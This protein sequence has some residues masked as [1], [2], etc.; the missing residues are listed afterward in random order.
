MNSLRLITQSNQRA[1]SASRS[2]QASGSELGFNEWVQSQKE[3]FAVKSE[4][5]EVTLTST[6]STS[7]RNAREIIDLTGDL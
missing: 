2:W 7:A 5:Q 6:A 3:L 4:P 1:Q